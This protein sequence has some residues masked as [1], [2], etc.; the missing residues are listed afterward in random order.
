MRVTMLLWTGTGVFF[1]VMAVVYWL[2]SGDPAGTSLF[3]LSI[4]FGWL[5]GLTAWFW[6]RRGG[7]GPEEHADADMHDASGPI[8]TVVPSS[9]GPFVA[10]IGITMVALSAIVG[11]WLGLP[12]V[13]VI[14]VGVV[15]LLRKPRP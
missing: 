6:L 11:P 5:A 14:L 8:G 13:G 15:P 7:D 12:G 4:F 9:I 1:V 10:A 2:L 3:V